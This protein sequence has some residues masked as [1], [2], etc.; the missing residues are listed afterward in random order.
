M[1]VLLASAAWGQGIASR[2]VSSAPRPKFSGKPWH[3]RFV[4]VSKEMGLTEPV[5]YGSDDRIDYLL[6]SSSGGLAFFDCNRDGYADLFVVAGTRF[7]SDPPNATNRLYRNEAGK[8]FT[9]VT[10]AAGLRRTGWASG[11]TV[12]DYDG[13]GFDDLFVTYWGQDVLYRNRGDGTFEDVTARA[14]L[15]RKE[16]RWSSGAT[17]IDYDRDGDLDLFVAEYMVFDPLRTPKPGFNAFCTWMGL[18]VACGP[19][20]QPASH[21]RLYRNDG[22]VFRDVSAAAGIGKSAKVFGMTAVAADFD[23]DGWPDIYLASDSTPS[24]FFHNRGN[25][26]FVE[27]GLERGVAVNEDGREQAGM[28][29]AVGDFD[30]NGHLDLFKTH[31][32]DDTPVLYRNDGKAL[33]TDVTL[34]AGLAVETR[35]VCWGTLFGDFDNDG[36]P[37][38]FTVTGHVYPEAGAKLAR[39]PYRTPRLLFRNLG[40]GRFEQIL[41]QPEVNRAGSSRGLAAADIDNDGDLDLAIWNRNEPVTLLRNDLSAAPRWLQ[42]EAPLG[43][44]VTAIY[45]GR[46]QTQEPLSQQSFYS[47]SGR[48]LHFGLGDADTATLE[49]RWPGGKREVRSGVRANQRIVLTRDRFE[50]GGQ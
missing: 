20:G 25:G 13:D 19:R 27:E 49:I 37:D 5:V 36:W 17:F 44:R 24:L 4:D 39:Y 3:A 2:S 38:L 14:G 21:A 6:E 46:R 15:A 16:V 41:D 40:S 23:N 29:V 31:F 47:S 9:D 45:G 30:L 28:G 10:A 1:L 35:Y 43:A 12:G 42:V 34:P 11:V 48:V 8:R 33:F 18:P 50:S 26:T 7:G 32:A 22:G